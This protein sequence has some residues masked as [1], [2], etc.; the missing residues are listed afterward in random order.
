MMRSGLRREVLRWCETTAEWG[1]LAYLVLLPLS[2]AAPWPIPTRILLGAAAVGGL[3]VV[4]A[5]GEIRLPHIWIVGLVMLLVAITSIS[6]FGSTDIVASGAAA[7]KVLLRSLV[8]FLLVACAPPEL[9]RWRRLGI[10]LATSALTLSVVSFGEAAFGVRNPWGGLV[11]PLFDYNSLC[12]FLIPTLPFAITA[13]AEPGGKAGRVFWLLGS[14]VV[15]TAIFLSFSRIGWAALGVLSAVL[16][17]TGRAGR[18]ILLVAVAGGAALFLLLAPDLRHINSVTD[19]T[20]FLATT[21][22]EPDASVMKAMRWK[23]LFTFNDRLEYAW[24]PALGIIR[25]HPLL[26]GGYGPDTFSRLANGKG[27]LL[28][29]EHNA[30]LAVAVQSGL[31]AA[32]TYLALLAVLVVATTNAVRSRG[33]YSPGE[34]SLLVALLGALLA[35]YVF[36]GLGEPTNNGRMGILFAALAG[37][38]ASLVTPRDRWLVVRLRRRR[39]PALEPLAPPPAGA[40]PHASPRQG[41]TP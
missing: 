3:V 37:F 8:V 1:L 26:G 41:K 38:V 21:N 24:I 23:D 9:A 28:T 25:E 16:W 22:V 40:A 10:A 11:G 4:L 14:T 5:R 27:P 29:H 13:A 7:S 33:A 32:A 2:H 34:H 19:N 20:R 15:T 35:E 39:T 12:M 17:L 18:R 36:Q 31:A 6:V 30:I